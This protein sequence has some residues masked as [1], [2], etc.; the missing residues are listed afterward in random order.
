MPGPIT[1]K[2]VTGFDEMNKNPNPQSLQSAG[3]G[4][5]GGSYS[6]S[7]VYSTFFFFTFFN[8]DY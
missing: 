7:F 2:H 6:Q 8:K 3:G 4:R 1:A 5:P